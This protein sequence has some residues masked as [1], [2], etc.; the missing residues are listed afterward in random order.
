MKASHW[1]GL[2]TLSVPLAVTGC[3]GGATDPPKGSAERRHEVEGKAEAGVKANLAQL[4]AEDRQ[5]AQAQQRCPI[6]G[7]RLG[8]PS[9]GVPFKELVKDQPVLLC[10]KSCQKKALAD[11]D[12]TL[13]KV[14]ELKAKT[15]PPKQ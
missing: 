11:P 5:L 2:L 10:C 9:M 6:S 12:K 1:L 14:Q 8:D 7:E 15:A 3:G 4:G 13:A